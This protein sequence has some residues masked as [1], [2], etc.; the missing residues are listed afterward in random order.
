MQL[1]W[2]SQGKFI[3]GFLFVTVILY[4]CSQ[5]CT[6][7]MEDLLQYGHLVHILP[8]ITIDP[9][10]SNVDIQQETNHFQ[11]SNSSPVCLQSLNSSIFGRNY[12]LPV[13]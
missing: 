11:T 10:E 3:I 13:E 12:M 9:N 8:P 6:P 7:D 1:F 2:H 5:P 4:P